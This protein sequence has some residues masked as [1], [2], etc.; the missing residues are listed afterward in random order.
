[1]SEYMHRLAN[2]PSLGLYHIHQHSRKAVPR[3]VVVSKQMKE[4]EQKTS[5]SIL[6]VE[7]STK[8]ITCLN[9]SE[10]FKKISDSLSNSIELIKKIKMGKRISSVDNASPKREEK[11]IISTENKLMEVHSKN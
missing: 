1:M 6:D 5:T 9:Q 10:S 7:D 4:L 8:V 3:M 2:E 11:Q